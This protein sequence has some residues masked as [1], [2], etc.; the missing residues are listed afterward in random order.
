MKISTQML[1]R[2]STHICRSIGAN[3]ARWGRRWA[4]LW[5]SFPIDEYGLYMRLPG[6]RP[7]PPPGSGPHRDIRRDEWELAA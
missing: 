4:K 1:A 5:A 2:K 6:E 7:P 3:C